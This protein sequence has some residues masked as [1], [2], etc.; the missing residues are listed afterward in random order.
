M[1]KLK[2]PAQY[3]QRQSPWS[4]ELLGYNTNSKYTIGDYGCL[5]TS[6]GNI[7]GLNPLYVNESLKSNNGFVKDSGEFIWNKCSVLG[8]T[9]TYVSP[10]YIGPVSSQGIDKIREL[11]GLGHPLIAEIDFNPATTTLEQHFLVLVGFDDNEIY[12]WDVWSATLVALSVYGGVARAVIQFRAYDKTLPFEIEDNLKRKANG[13]DAIREKIKD[14]SDS[15]DVILLD[16]EKLLGQETVISD[17]EKIIIA[18]DQQIEEVKKEAERLQERVA[19][20]QKDNV[21]MQEKLA[22]AQKDLAEQE[23][24]AQKQEVALKE[25]STQLSELQ[26]IKPT[27]RPNWIQ[28]LIDAI[29]S[30]KRI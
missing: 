19:Q 9:Q 12:A 7:V 30:W 20:L 27:T 17:K 1:K 24:T 14:E 4:D 15:I 6:L 13:Y 25:L 10:R 23:I 29:K 16:L 26:A 8:L 18:K 21:D 22:T 3:G 11:I 28:Q 2:L 5:I